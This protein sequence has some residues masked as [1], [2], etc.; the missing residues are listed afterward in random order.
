VCLA[1]G[2]LFG[3]LQGAGTGL[4]HDVT[5]VGAVLWPLGA[6]ITGQA[7]WVNVDYKRTPLQSAPD[8]PRASDV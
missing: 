7:I 3:P 5:W 6:V 4:P 2:F 8:N 1:V